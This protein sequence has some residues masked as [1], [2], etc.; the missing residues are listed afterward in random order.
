MRPTLSTIPRTFPRF[1]SPGAVAGLQPK[2]AAVFV[3]G[4]FLEGPTGVALFERYAVCEDLVTQLE[5]FCRKKLSANPGLALTV[6]RINVREGVIHKSWGLSVEEVDWIMARLS[7]V[8]AWPSLDAVEHEE[9]ALHR[10]KSEC[11][12]KVFQLSDAEAGRLL[13]GRWH[14]PMIEP[15]TM[16]SLILEKRE[17]E[18]PTETPTHM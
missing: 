2:L 13:R 7:D 16:V 6:F 15:R 3:D 14:P 10:R 9:S 18:S 12:L 17:Q 8:M 11:C 1:S 5:V 4:K